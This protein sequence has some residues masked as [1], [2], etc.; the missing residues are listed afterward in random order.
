MIAIREEN[1]R[2]GKLLLFNLARDTQAYI[3]LHRLAESV[4]LA[5]KTLRK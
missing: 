1:I 5:R 4:Q 2:E 3:P